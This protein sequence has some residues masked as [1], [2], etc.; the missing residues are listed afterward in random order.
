MYCGYSFELPQLVEAIQMSTQNI[1]LYVF[2]KEVDK[3][4]KITKL[5][6]CA[7]IEACAVI[8]SNMEVHFLLFCY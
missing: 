7:V 1:I 6:D 3:S 4:L 5:L 8:T 2:Y